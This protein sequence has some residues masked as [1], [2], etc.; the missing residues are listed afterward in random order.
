MHNRWLTMQLTTGTPRERGFETMKTQPTT[1][2]AQATPTTAVYELPW[3]HNRCEGKWSRYMPFMSTYDESLCLNSSR[4]SK[5]P[6]ADGSS[7]PTPHCK[8]Q[9]CQVEHPHC[10]VQVP[11]KEANVTELRQI[12]RQITWKHESEKDLKQ[13][14]GLSQSYDTFASSFSPGMSAITENPQSATSP[15]VLM[16]SRGD[17]SQENDSGP[18]SRTRQTNEDDMVIEPI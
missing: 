8:S 13:L 12:V 9:G 7:S 5:M 4:P 18:R 3:M 11:M 15:G 2:I 14:A 16:T 6:H 1:H 17:A 10:E